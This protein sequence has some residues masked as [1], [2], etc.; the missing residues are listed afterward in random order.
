MQC[1]KLEFPIIFVNVVHFWG[2]VVYFSLNIY[3]S[4]WLFSCY[5]RVLFPLFFC[6]R[7][8]HVFEYTI[9]DGMMTRAG[10]GEKERAAR[11]PRQQSVSQQQGS[12]RRLYHRYD[13]SEVFLEATTRIANKWARLDTMMRASRVP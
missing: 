13:R 3:V 7:I 5:H 6:Q 2:S 4:L 11:G 12:R 10:M 1:H 8:V 9:A